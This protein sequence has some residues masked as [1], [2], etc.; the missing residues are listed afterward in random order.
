[1]KDNNWYVITGGPCSGK[2]SILNELKKIGFKV[3]YEQ[4]RIYIDRELKDGKSLE[5]IRKNEFLFQLKVLEMKVN[6]ENKLSPDKLLF[7]ERGIPDTA[8]YL[9]LINKDKNIILPT[10]INPP[11]YRKVFLLRILPYE[12]DYARTESREEA[13][14]LETLLE[15]SYRQL[16]INLVKIPV[17]PL[18]KRVKYIIS[19]L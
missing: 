19:H 4:A 2:T 3:Y 14:L 6:F 17:M 8:A 12:K 18:T 13:L 7:I 11:H 15:K 9:K 5:Q 1:M 16:H 10:P